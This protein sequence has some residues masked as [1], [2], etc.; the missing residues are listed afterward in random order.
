MR[1]MPFIAESGPLTWAALPLLAFLGRAA[2]T[3]MRA[4]FATEGFRTGR[5]VLLAL[6]LWFLVVHLYLQPINRYYQ[7]E[8]ATSDA[9]KHEWL[10]KCKH[11]PPTTMF[12]SHGCLETQVRILSGPFQAAFGQHHDDMMAALAYYVEHTWYITLVVA[13][14]CLLTLAVLLQFFFDYQQRREAARLAHQTK[15]AAQVL[16]GKQQQQSS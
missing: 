6:A 10:L 7:R 11:D 3:G 14:A 13:L 8:L 16:L 4:A 15:T 5:R 12:L 1:A 2:A 9:Y